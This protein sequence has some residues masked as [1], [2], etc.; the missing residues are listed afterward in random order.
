VAI[1]TV[2]VCLG[3]LA[4]HISARSLPLFASE[5]SL[6]PAVPSAIA[7]I[8]LDEVRQ[9]MEEP[10]VIIIDAR[11]PEAFA[12]GHVRGAV[13]LP[14]ADFQKQQRSMEA[15]LRAAT[16][17]ICY[18]DGITCDDGARLCALLSAAGYRNTTLMF[19]GWEGWQKAGYPTSSGGAVSR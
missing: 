16:L 11:P 1:V 6:R 2:A 17:L 14:A 8:G 15:R 18:C 3:L 13:S 4:N 9:R 5:E 10:G 7:Y 19:E 12:S